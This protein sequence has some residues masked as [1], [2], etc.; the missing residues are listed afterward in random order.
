[1]VVKI[2]QLVAEFFIFITDRV[3]YAR[4]FPMPP[5]FLNWRAIFFDLNSFLAY[6]WDADASILTGSAM[7]FVFKVLLAWDSCRLQV[8]DC[9]Q[10]KGD[11]F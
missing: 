9:S 3:P 2:F 4:F 6:S 8:Y 5:L 11:V 1:V 10:M 7:V